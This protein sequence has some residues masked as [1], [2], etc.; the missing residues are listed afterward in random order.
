MLNNIITLGGVFKLEDWTSYVKNNSE[1]DVPSL[2][3]R[4][5]PWK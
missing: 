3:A 5:A 2:K 4:F 1:N